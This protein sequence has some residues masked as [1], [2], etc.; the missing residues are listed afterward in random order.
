MKEGEYRR[1]IPL[2]SK[3]TKVRERK[4]KKKDGQEWIANDARRVI[5]NKVDI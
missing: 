2:E 3:S 5:Q 1:R 4:K